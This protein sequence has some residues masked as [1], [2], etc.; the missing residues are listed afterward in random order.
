MPLL[1][2]K[3]VTA[4]YGLGQA[5]GGIDLS[6]EP[7]ELVGIVGPNGHGK[8]TLLRTISGLMAKVGGRIEFGGQSIIGTAPERIAQKGIVHVPQG[9][10]VYKNMTILENLLVGGYA[11]RSEARSQAQ[12]EKIYDLFP[13]LKERSGQMASSL[14]GGERRMLGIGRGLMMADCRILMLD[15]PSLGLAPVVIDQIYTSIDELRASGMTIVVVEENITRVAGHADKLHLMDGGHFVW[16]G[17]PGEIGQNKKIID[18]Y[19]GA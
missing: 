6:V 16:T 12:L 2:L 3:N 13:K 19:L 14:S 7:G 8:T 5:L 4:S 17:V 10:L 1:D 11:N 18:T 15:E 9:D